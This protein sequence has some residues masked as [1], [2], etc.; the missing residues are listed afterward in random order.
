M[1]AIP[2]HL[3]DFAQEMARTTIPRFIKGAEDQTVR[4]SY[5][6]NR[7]LQGGRIKKGE[8]GTGLYWLLKIRLPTVTPLSNHTVM[9]FTPT[10]KH[11][12][13]RN[14]L[15]GYKT[16]E[17][18]SMIDQEINKGASALANL[19]QE[20]GNDLRAAMKQDL[21]GE[22]Y[23]SGSSA[24]RTDRYE[25]LET[26]LGSGTVTVADKIA[27]PN[28]A[29]AGQDTDLAVNGGFWSAD[30][31]TP[32][33][34]SLAKDWPDG[35]GDPQYDCNSPILVNTG[36]DA[37][38]TG[39]NDHRVNLF[40]AISQTQIWLKLLGAQA[41]DGLT[42]VDGWS[43]QGMRENQEAK[44]RLVQP[45]KSSMDIGMVGSGGALYLD[46][47]EIQPD[48]WCPPMTAYTFSMQNVSLHSWFEEGL[49][50]SK[51]PIELPQMSFSTIWALFTLG[52][53]K[54]K[55]MRGAAKYYP[56]ATS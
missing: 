27:V 12:E 35:S 28:G 55:S 29:Y 1:T 47:M 48:F 52:N 40:R 4:G 49:F 32:N 11:I 15:R 2:L 13:M 56:Y 19:F 6:F 3:G 31:T 9:D 42:V 14:G 24:G 21:Q 33:N 41:S 17:S 50:R 36:S 45:A 34:A 53:I 54:Y 46:G 37:W 7:L 8:S 10:E 38:G 39:S 5:F 16:Q 44:M 23:K 20:K 22:C 30:L 26:G 25:G 43:F 18:M 51:G